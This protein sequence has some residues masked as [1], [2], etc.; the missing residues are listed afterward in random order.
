MALELILSNARIS[1]DGPPMVDIGVEDGKIAAIGQSLTADCETLDAGGRLVSTGLIE[2]HIHLD[3]SRIL[4]RCSPAPNRGSDHMMRVAAV[5]E[6]FTV[7]DVYE[8]ARQTLE[9]CIVYGT[10]HMRTH[11][12]VD[13]NVGLR[14][15]KALQ[16]LAKDYS[17]AIDLDLCVFAQ[18]GMSNV[19]EADANVVEG[20][21]LNAPV[22][23]GAPK[24]DADPAAQIKR[25]FELSREYDVDVDLHLDVGP[26]ADDMDIHLV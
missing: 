9:Q 18:E 12:E 10:T 22:I 7:E 15:F 13:P 19:P 25:V 8:R 5:K 11:V 2:T 4:D 14:G 20:L 6:A 24:Y 23:G 26:S 1:G 21:K 17:W 16:Q 3:K